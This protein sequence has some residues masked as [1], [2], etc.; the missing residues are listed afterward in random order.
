MCLCAGT[1]YIELSYTR[2]IPIEPELQT[3]N[4]EVKFMAATARSSDRRA[5]V[6]LEPVIRNPPSEEEVVLPTAPNHA[7]SRQSYSAKCM[8][9]LG[10]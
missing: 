4:G 9:E 3:Q 6:T 7:P 1:F 2:V 8:I 5:P 10:G